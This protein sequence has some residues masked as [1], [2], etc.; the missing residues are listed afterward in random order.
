MFL[1]S[2]LVAGQSFMSMASL[3]LELWQFS[4][5]TDWPEIQKLEIP[6]SE[7]YLI[8]GDWGK[9]W[10]PNLAEIYLMKCYWMLQNARVAAFAISE[11]FR[12]NQ[13]GGKITPSLPQIRVKLKIISALYMIVGIHVTVN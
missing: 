4:F 11:L 9:I 6:L 10:I 1:L 3:V 7:F 2:S 13:Q 12:E 5:I 8:S